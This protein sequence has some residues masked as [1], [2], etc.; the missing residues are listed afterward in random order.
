MTSHAD[1]AYAHPVSAGRCW[2]GGQA[3]ADGRGVWCMEDI[4]HDLAAAPESPGT[5]PTWVCTDSEPGHVHDEACCNCG[6]QGHCCS[7]CPAYEDGS[8]HASGDLV[9]PGEP[10]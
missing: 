6:R 10:S 7:D 4:H 5:T 9:T 8:S 3:H 2:C 1:D